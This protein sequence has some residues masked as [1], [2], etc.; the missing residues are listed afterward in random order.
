MHAGKQPFNWPWSFAYIE[1]ESLPCGKVGKAKEI[2]NRRITV[3]H[4][5]DFH[6]L[7]DS[8][9]MLM[10]STLLARASMLLGVYIM[11]QPRCTVAHI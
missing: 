11:G 7:L 1:I 6:V 8:A 2:G 10:L 5:S 9:S 4:A 3:S